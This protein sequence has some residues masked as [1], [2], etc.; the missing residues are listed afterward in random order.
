MD[1]SQESFF[2]YSI[3]LKHK[4]GYQVRYRS[5]G[6]PGLG[7][8]LLKVVWIRGKEVEIARRHIVYIHIYVHALHPKL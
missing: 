3:T 8:S 7:A 6:I 2:R 5:K 4:H 1:L